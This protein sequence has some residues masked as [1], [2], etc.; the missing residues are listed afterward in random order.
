M[1]LR[2]SAVAKRDLAKIVNYIAS[3]KPSAA[4]K[5]RKAFYEKCETLR[6]TP[7]IGR[8]VDEIRHGMRMFP[9]GN[10]LI[11]YRLTP[12]TIDI[13]HVTHGARDLLAL[14]KD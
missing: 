10:Y 7:E 4:L 2:I 9:F 11:I 3:D 5:W 12:E 8:K 1:K 13:I 14:L 6:T